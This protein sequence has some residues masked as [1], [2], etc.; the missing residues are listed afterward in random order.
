MVRPCWGD[1]S[2]LK[3]HEHGLPDMG[4]EPTV[5]CILGSAQK[6]VSSLLASNSIR[7]DLVRTWLSSWR[8]L[9]VHARTRSSAAGDAHR[10]N[11]FCQ[12][13][14]FGRRR[15]TGHYP[16]CKQAAGILPSATNRKGVYVLKPSHF[17]IQLT[18]L[19]TAA[20]ACF[21]LCVLLSGMQV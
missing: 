16:L 11:P 20:R 19:S 6:L 10:L 5:P 7:T 9:S 4:P 13:S 17:L 8:D 15:L 1:P 18:C 12:D 2:S 14:S 3:A 21:M